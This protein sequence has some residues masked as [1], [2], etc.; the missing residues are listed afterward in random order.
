MFEVA[1]G[2]VQESSISNVGLLDDCV[3][4][5]A[6]VKKM[7]AHCAK[8]QA[9]DNR[10]ALLQVLNTLSP[11]FI[12][13]AAMIYFFSSAYIITALLTVP[14]AFL[15][16]RL[17]IIQHDCG[18]NAFFSSRKWNNRLGRFLSVLTWTPYDFWRR[19][20][21]LHHSS[22][23]NLDNRGFGAIET[24][25]IAE[26]EALSP[27][28]KFWY[29]VYRN[30]YI[31]LLLGT[32]FFIIV[33]QRFASVK[34]F[35]FCSVKQSITFQQVWKSVFGLNTAL[36]GVYGGAGLMLGL[37][38]VLLT[39]VP[40]VIGTSWIGGW[41]FFIQHQFEDAHWDYQDSWDYQ[42]AAV[43]GS[44]HYDLPPILHW[45]TGNIGLHH[46]HHLNARI[47]NY[48]LHDCMNANDDLKKINR[49]RFWQS[50]KYANLSLW[51]EDNRKMIT[52]A[53]LA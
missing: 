20:H 8:Y 13:C 29:K 6:K 1:E 33:G 10:K 21:N 42:E 30:P 18:H 16:V 7:V 52:F 41:L 11:F 17:F 39:Y 50:L 48:R 38:I 27:K 40:I 12:V 26:Y 24:I 34:A 32:P 43:M 49:V 46:I 36:V 22:S 51:D 9:A 4:I 2:Q 45:F 5:K 19:T 35:P 25:T 14:A 3:E 31:L 28:L 44:S 23:G 37:D 47:P 15:L 53:Q